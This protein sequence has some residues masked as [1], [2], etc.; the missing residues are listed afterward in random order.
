MLFELLWVCTEV[1]PGKTQP[2]DIVLSLLAETGL[3]GASTPIAALPIIRRG[4][5][6]PWKEYHLWNQNEVEFCLLY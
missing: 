1:L 4:S 5:G 3:Y 6:T 2:E